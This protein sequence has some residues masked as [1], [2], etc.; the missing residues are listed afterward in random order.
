MPEQMVRPA[1][2]L[3][4]GI[5]VRSPE[6]K[7]L[8][9]KVLD[10]ELAFC[11]FL[12][13]PLMAGIEPARMPGHCHDAGLTLNGEDPFRICQRVGDWNFDFDVFPGMHALDCLL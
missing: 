1:S 9:H 13:D 10:L 8:N 11:D 3:S 5:H 4:F 7:R 6:E 2:G 12:M